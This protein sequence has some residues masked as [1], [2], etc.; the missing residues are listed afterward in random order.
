LSLDLDYVLAWARAFAFTQI[1]EA[2]IYRRALRVAW[3]RALA[4]SALTHP[5]VWFA[6]PLLSSA[7][8]LGWTLAMTLAEVFAWIVEAAFFVVTR[9]RV[10][11]RR[12]VFASLG[13]N[14]GSL[15]LGLTIRAVFGVP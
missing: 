15:V 2:P 3:W 10:R 11:W 8:G 7:L 13:A 4:P 1:V 9:P 14:G 12:A 6:S 5:F